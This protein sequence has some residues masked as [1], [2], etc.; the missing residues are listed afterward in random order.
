LNG[1]KKSWQIAG[2]G[3]NEIFEIVNPME[4]TRPVTVSVD[5]HV[6]ETGGT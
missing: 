4:H 5:G 2:K 6:P 3:H 1:I